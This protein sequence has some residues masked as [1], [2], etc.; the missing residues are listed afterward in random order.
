MKPIFKRFI[1]ISFII[2]AIIGIFISLGGIYGAWHVRSSLLGKLLETTKIVNS[3]LT[4][5]Y[6]GMNV[7]NDTLDEAMETL[8]S[9]EVVM[10]SMAQT[11]GSINDLT[12]GFLGTLGSL[13][14]P[15]FQSSEEPSEDTKPTQDFSTVES[16]I[17]N[18]A[19]NF[20]KINNAMID[21][22]AVVSSYQKVVISTQDQIDDFQINGPKWIT[23]ITW[24]LTVLLVW[25]AI[26][27][28]GFI[29]QGMEF[30]NTAKVQ[31][32]EGLEKPTND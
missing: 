23:T 30:I 9:S 10:F 20:T 26:T 28:I 32:N 4:T 18:I 15:G 7:L 25:F 2:F 17:E 22:Q 6:K 16:E 5:T 31:E 3:T 19:R 21:A 11:I 14:L 8:E 24:G 1:G 29:F 27:Q 13:R 12:S